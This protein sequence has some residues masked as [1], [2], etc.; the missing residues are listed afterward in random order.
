MAEGFDSRERLVFTSRTTWGEAGD[1]AVRR[2][3]RS[4]QMSRLR[5][6]VARAPLPELASLPWA[7]RP[8]ENRRRYLELI[9]A[10]AATRRSDVVFSHVSA[11]AILGYPYLGQ[12]PTTVDILEAPEAHRRTKNGVVVHR[13]SFG[14]SDL[15]EF[16]GML[17]TT[18]ARTLA[19]LA[20]SGQ[21]RACVVALDFAIGKQAPRPLRIA[22]EELLA[23][24]AKHG[25]WGSA[26]ARGI[27][28]F[29]DGRSGSPGES[30]SRLLFAQWGFEPPDLQVRYPTASGSYYEVDFRWAR[31]ARGRPLVGEFDGLGKYLKPEYLGSS[32]TAGI[33]VAEKRREDW[34]RRYDGSDFMRWG[35]ADVTQP[36]SL[37]RLAVEQGVP[38]AR[39]AASSARSGR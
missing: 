32:T 4:G 20:R 39:R 19:D 37:R 24:I 35:M 27:V 15:M 7:A 36:R 33:V 10:V 17:V 14:D 12:W 26:R 25:S 34:I 8:E 23:A 1:L 30:G 11:L 31:S 28:E 6:G 21:D 3:I 22:K 13:S 38:I 2:A 18:P 16:D 9:A 29:A 5:R